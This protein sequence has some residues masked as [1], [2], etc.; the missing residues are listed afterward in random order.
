MVKVLKRL[1]MQGTDLNIKTIYSKFTVN[2]S[3]EKFKRISTK[4][5]NKTRIPTLYESIHTKRNQGGKIGKE[6][7]KVSLFADDIIVY[8]VSLTIPPRNSYS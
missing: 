8:R 2:V 5:R 7:L 4:D 3:M 1:G 6:K